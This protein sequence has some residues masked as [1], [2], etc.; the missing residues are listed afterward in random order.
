MSVI[1]ALRDPRDGEVRYIGKCNIL[2]KRLCAHRNERGD[3]RKC[4]WIAALGSIGLS[5]TIEALEAIDGDW[6]AAE[7]R[8]IAH[9]RAL[10]ADLCNHTD[11]GEGLTNASPETRQKLSAYRSNDWAINR[12][13]NLAISRSPVRRD[14]ISKALSGKPKTKEHVAK[15]PQNSP[16]WK[17][18]PE[19]K[20]KI[21]AASKG[22]QHCAGRRLTAEHKEKIRATSTGRRYPNRR[23]MSA[24][25]NERRSVSLKG[26][27]K[28]KEW[29]K[30]ARIAALRRWARERERKVHVELR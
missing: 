10:G 29:K 5:P 6:Q 8:W 3:T 26:R 16:G 9:Y 20:A 4:Q 22:N 18:T 11:G 28:S 24:D 21:A 17:H 15:L 7:R 13:K 25:S 1:Y 12:E 27:P 23:P 14:K 30:K 2:G 19:A